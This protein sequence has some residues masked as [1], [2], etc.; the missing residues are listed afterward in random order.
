MSFL[1]SVSL[2]IQQPDCLEETMRYVLAYNTLGGN[3]E[4]A[5]TDRRSQGESA[6]DTASVINL[7]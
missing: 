4:G 5:C 3:I 7:K 6:A 2:V 1:L